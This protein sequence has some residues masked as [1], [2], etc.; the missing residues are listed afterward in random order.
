MSALLPKPQQ[1]ATLIEVLIAIVVLSIGLLGL[2]G[3]Q[4]TSMQSNHSAYY[5]SQATLLAYD[6]ADRMRT[7]RTAAQASAYVFAYPTS[8]SSTNT[9]SGTTAQKDKAEWL[10]NLALTLPDG[11]GKVEQAGTL[12]TISVQ[13]NDNRGRIKATADTA[14][15]SET[16]VYRTEI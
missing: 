11:M 15:P 16:F 14:T 1:G 9:V 2:A 13:W 8:S 6:L 7:N 10:N 5:R 3:L 4:V 12:V